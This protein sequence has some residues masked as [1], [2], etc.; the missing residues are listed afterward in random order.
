[1]SGTPELLEVTDTPG[2]EKRQRC[3]VTHYCGKR[4]TFFADERGASPVPFPGPLAAD[5]ACACEEELYPL[6]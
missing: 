3:D 5:L 2:T 4:N 1:M 6:L